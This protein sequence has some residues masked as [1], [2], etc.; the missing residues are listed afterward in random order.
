MATKISIIWKRIK[1]FIIYAPT[2][3]KYIEGLWN[4]LKEV[5]NEETLEEIEEIKI[6]EKSKH[7]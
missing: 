7:N 5:Y 6:K 1:A 4:T 2:I 3:I